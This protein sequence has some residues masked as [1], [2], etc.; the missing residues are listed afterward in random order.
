MLR[1]RRDAH[2]R[3]GFI[4]PFAFATVAAL[5]QPLVGHVLGCGPGADR[6]RPSSPRS[7]WPP[8]PRARSPLR[9]G[10]VLIDGEVRGA[11]DI[12]R[13]GSIIARNSFDQAGAGPGHHPAPT[14]AR[15]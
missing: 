9:L 15:R 12:P 11:I 4:V 10:G 6:S 2:H 1:G 5:A 13:L 7:S 14:T 3:L 8:P